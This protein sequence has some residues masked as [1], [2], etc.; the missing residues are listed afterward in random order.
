[1]RNELVTQIMEKY[2][3]LSDEQKADFRKFV[4][5]L[6]HEQQYRKIKHI[7]REQNANS[8]DWDTLMYY[9]KRELST[10]EYNKDNEC[11]LYL[12]AYY[13]G[14]IQGKRAERARRKVAHHE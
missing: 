13:Y 4:Y 12:D 1:M 2:D 10:G 14:Y 3:L 9:I 5:E 6:Q 7:L 11:L 8:G